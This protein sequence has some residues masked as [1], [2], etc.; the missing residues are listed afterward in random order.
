MPASVLL[1]DEQTPTLMFTVQA[2]GNGM[3][4][5]KTLIKD[6]DGNERKIDSSIEATWSEAFADIAFTMIGRSEYLE[7]VLKGLRKP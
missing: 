1:M 6:T 3:W 4:T 7:D 2:Y 5:I